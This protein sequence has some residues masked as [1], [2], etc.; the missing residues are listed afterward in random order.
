MRDKYHFTYVVIAQP[1]EHVLFLEAKSRTCTEQD[2]VPSRIYSF[3]GKI[4]R[5][6]KWIYINLV[7]QS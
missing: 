3:I 5:S 2:G 4:L 1:W 7:T 6:Q